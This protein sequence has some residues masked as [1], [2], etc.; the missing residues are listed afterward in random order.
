MKYQPPGSHSE[1][2]ILS[3]PKLIEHDLP[4]LPGYMDSRIVQTKA[5]KRVTTMQDF[6][7]VENK[8]YMLESSHLAPDY[9]SFFKKFAPQRFRS[10]CGKKIP[11]EKSV[12]L[13]EKEVKVEVLD[14]PFLH[15]YNGEGFS[16]AS[17]LFRELAN[18]D[19][20]S[21]FNSKAV[22]Y[23]IDFNWQTTKIY[24]ILFLFLPFVLFQAAFI[25]YSN[26][27]NG[28]FDNPDASFEVGY[29]LLS[30]L[31]YLFSLYF[32]INELG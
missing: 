31:L 9:S 7:P 29:I 24:T 21:I 28:Q 32:L 5:H 19:N 23:L 2:T 6:E 4:S 27:Y 16:H 10:I 20:M 30:A 26:V 13:K 15:S 25:A 18:A 22:Q 17:G 14:L 12:I 3:L 1:Y 8:D 11:V